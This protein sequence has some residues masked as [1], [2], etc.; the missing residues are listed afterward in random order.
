[1]HYFYS[2]SFWKR[3]RNQ[4]FSIGSNNKVNKVKVFLNEVKVSRHKQFFQH[5]QQSFNSDLESWHDSSCHLQHSVNRIIAVK[6]GLLI[7]LVRDD[8]DSMTKTL[9]KRKV[10]PVKWTLSYLQVFVVGARQALQRHHEPCTLERNRSSTRKLWFCRKKALSCIFMS[11]EGTDLTEV[12]KWALQW[13]GKKDDLTKRIFSLTLPKTRPALLLI[14]SRL[15]AFFFWGIR[16][17]PVLH[18]HNK[19]RNIEEWISTA[20]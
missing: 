16:L 17:L 4:I 5:N 2:C 9:Q 3:N 18:T 10:H 19:Y 12:E 6:H 1:M 11:H 14:S 8:K 20:Q 13:A 7:L 15:S